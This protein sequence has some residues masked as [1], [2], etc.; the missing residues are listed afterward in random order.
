[1]FTLLLASLMALGLADPTAV[2]A[3][4]AHL[5]PTAPPAAVPPGPPSAQA[6]LLYLAQVMDQ[7]HDRFP[8][9]D[10]VSSGGNHFFAW[11]KIPDQ[12]AAVAINGSWTD[13]P[14]SGATAIRAEFDDTTGTN[15]GGFYF[16]NG[17]LPAGATAPLPNFGQ[18]ADAGLDLSGATALTGRADSAAARESAYSWVEWG[19]TR[20]PA[21]RRRPSPTRLPWSSRPSA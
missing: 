6:A 14:H 5:S 1:M 19:E 21:S 2:T 7:Y 9:Y 17:V 11:S 16:L 20:A 15:F 8:V 4:S 12:N 3:P 18:V 10:D 13:N